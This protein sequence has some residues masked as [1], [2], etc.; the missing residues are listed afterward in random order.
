M[1]QPLIAIVGD[2]NP[3]R[4]LVPSLANPPLARKAAE[5]LGAE[6][7][8][9]NVRL[10]VYGGPFLEADVVR[11]YVGARPKADKSVLMWYSQGQV[12]PPFAEEAAHPKL[13]D[14]HVDSGTDWE[15]AFYRSITSADGVLLMGGANSAKISGLIAIGSRMP[16]LALSEFGGGTAQVWN[17]LSAG[18]DLPTRGEIDTMARPWAAGSAQ[19]GVAALLAQLDRKRTV[20]SALKPSQVLVSAALFICALAIVPWVWASNA[21]EAWMLFLAPLLAGGAGAT[22]RPAADLLRGNAIQ[23]TPL[24]V[25][26]AVGLVTGGIAGVLFVTAQLT[27]NPDVEH[28][29]SYAR[30]SIPFA[31][32]VGFIAG[33]TSDSVF[34]KLLGINVIRTGGVASK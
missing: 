34:G 15:T 2:I 29:A 12:P 21:W 32:A 24:L 18:S 14:R 5:E 7:A 10:L 13:F 1:Q 27:G 25:T 30:H 6:L 17:A 26:L 22:I 23:P 9:R 19:A 20:V 11:G 28:I 8:K 31:L 4:P 33:L 3:Q 16:I